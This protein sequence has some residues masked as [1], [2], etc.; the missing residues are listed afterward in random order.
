V[1]KVIRVEDGDTLKL[2][3]DDG[4]KVS[5]RLSDIDAPEVFHG[6]T[7]PG[8]PYSRASKASLVALVGGR[9]ATATC[10]EYDRWKRP[11]CTV[12]VDGIDV[13]AEQLKRGMAWANQANPRYV[14][15]AE[16]YSFESQAKALK[17]GIWADNRQVPPWEWRRACWTNAVCDGAAE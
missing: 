16:S 11:V 8:Q 5:L 3:L 1:G 9:Q 15:N 12:F 10:Y 4:S 17:V 6:Q 13:G 2:M 7:R 14:R